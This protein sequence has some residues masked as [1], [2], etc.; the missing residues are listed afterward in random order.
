MLTNLAK[1]G[2]A[3]LWGAGA[4]VAAVTLD[5]NMALSWGLVV[6]LLGVLGT[7]TWKL[8]RWMQ[9]VDDKLDALPCQI[10]KKQ[11]CPEGNDKNET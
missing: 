6:F 7:G 9:K 3:S 5:E 4:T 2:M 8:A 11:K 10:G 1:L